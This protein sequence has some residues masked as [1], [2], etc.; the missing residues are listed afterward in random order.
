MRV[1]IYRRVSTPAQTD[2]FSLETQFEELTQL[3]ESN[4]WIWDDYCDPGISGEKLD[5]RPQMMEFLSRIA[6]YGAVLVWDP[7]RLARDELVFAVIRNQLRTARVRVITP[8]GETDLNDPMGNMVSGMLAVFAQ[9]E[10]Q[11]RTQKTKAGLRAAAEA[12]YWTGGDAPYGYQLTR[13]DDGHTTLEI[14]QHEAETL[15]L[16]VS[17][18]IDDGLSTFETCRRLEALGHS[19]RTGRAWTHRNLRLKLTR[20]HLI[21]EV[22]FETEDESIERVFPPILDQDRFQALQLALDR[23]AG[24]QEQHR[25][26]PLSKRLLCDCGG[27][28]VGHY[29]ND[30]GH[31]YYICNR[32]TSNAINQ[33]TCPVSP[34]Y[35]RADDI[36]RLIWNQLQETISNPERLYTAASAALDEYREAAPRRTELRAELQARLNEIKQERVRTFRDAKRLGLDD[37]EVR[38]ILNDLSNERSTIEDQLEQCEQ[39]PHI[40]DLAEISERLERIA[41]TS[42]ADLTDADLDKQKEILE[43]LDVQVMPNEDG[44]TI[45]GTLPYWAGERG[46]MATQAPQRP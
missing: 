5:E 39:E 8:S 12:G 30:R 25:P 10:Q 35:R 2:G 43:L 46:K 11:L 18:I 33:D 4:G 34:R 24:S 23:Q 7:S 14:N 6:D 31:R 42:A 15:R 17:L 45:N 40:A 3:A 37:D 36:E 41:H 9:Y 21:G 26:Y 44:Y 19:T 38:Q 1:A 28:R 29:R 13:T 16:A 27:T 22:P 32:N 20:R